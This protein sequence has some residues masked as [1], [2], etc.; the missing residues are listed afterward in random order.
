MTARPRRKAP[1]LEAPNTIEEATAL[2]GEYAACLTQVESIRADADASIAAIQAARDG[3]LKPLD[4]RMKDIFRQ[5]RAWW[6]VAGEAITEGKRK[7]TEI[8]GCL[9]GERT[10]PPKL[11]MAKG[12]DEEDAVDAILAS[13][14]DD[15]KL[16]VTTMKLA[17]PTLI[18]LLKDAES[19]DARTLRTI[20]LFLKQTEEFFIDRAAPKPAAAET[21]AVEG[22]AA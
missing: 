7:S 2:L 17:K 22:E 21:V 13:D 3:F 9:V 6:A 14:L 4:E 15:E 8:S 10:T 18:Q 20:G 11:A 5:L 19:D 12:M 1:R 16:I